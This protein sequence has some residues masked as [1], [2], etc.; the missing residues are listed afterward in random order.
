METI[1]EAFTPKFPPIILMR[2]ES[3]G[4]DF[5]NGIHG[6]LNEELKSSLM[7]DY[8]RIFPND[9]DHHKKICE[10][11]RNSGTKSFDIHVNANGFHVNTSYSE[12]EEALTLSRF[13][14]SGVT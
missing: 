7:E 8:Y 9:P 2:F 12:I 13:E 11:L 10:Y 1:P 14:I 3:P 6:S 5:F 4:K